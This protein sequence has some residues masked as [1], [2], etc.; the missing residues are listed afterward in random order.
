MPLG[1]SQGDLLKMDYYTSG[2]FAEKCQITKKTLYYYEKIGLLKPIKVGDNGYRYYSLEQTDLVATIRLLERLGSSLSE[3]GKFLKQS[4][5]KNKEIYLEQKQVKL[6]EQ[7]KQLQ[8]M[9]DDIA[10]L[11]K[12]LNK[13]KKWGLN[14]VF[15]E[16]VEDTEYYVT[17]FKHNTMLNPTTFGNHYGVIVDDLNCGN[18]SHFFKEVQA[19]QGNYIKSKGKYV[20]MFVKTDNSETS[21][22]ISKIIPVMKKY[23]SGPLYVEDYSSSVLA[24][25]NQTITKFT[26]KIEENNNII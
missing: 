26:A 9:Q 10:N 23:S 12:R 5:L 11:K 20:S 22:M 1:D 24:G 25:N 4:D 7:I 18:L 17:D 21:T 6:S 14:K 19:G 13:L 8:N 2:E 3:I 15:T 16:D